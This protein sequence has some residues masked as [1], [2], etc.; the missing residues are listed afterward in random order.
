MAISKESLTFG[1]KVRWDIVDR[2]G[3]KMLLTTYAVDYKKKYNDKM[4]SDH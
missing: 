4:K 2:Y 1:D 3:S